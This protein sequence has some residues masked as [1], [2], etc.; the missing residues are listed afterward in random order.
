MG[1]THPWHGVV[2]FVARVGRSDDQNFELLVIG[3][4]VGHGVAPRFVEEE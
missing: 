4:V 1:F 3:F 2:R